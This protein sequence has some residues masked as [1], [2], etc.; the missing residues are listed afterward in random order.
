MDLKS[1]S[2]WY[3]YSRARDEMFAATDM[4]FAPWYVVRSDDKKRAR[5]NLI[6]HLLGQI[7]YEELPREKIKLPKREKPRGYQRAG[8]AC[9]L[10]RGGVSDA[11]GLPDSTRACLFDLD[12]VLTQTAKLHAAAWKEMFDDYLRERA[13][14]T[15]E[16]FVP[17]EQ[18][19]TTR[20][21]STASCASTAR[22]A[23]LASRGIVLPDDEV[24]RRWP[25]RKDELARRAAATASA[26]RPTRARCA[27][28]RR[29]ATRGLQD[30]GG[31]VEQALPGGARVGRASPTCSTC[32]STATSPSEEHLAGKPAP[33][34]FLA[35]AARRRRRRRRRRPCSRTRSPAS[36]PGAPGHFGYVVGVDRAGQA[37]ELARHGADVVVDDLAALLEAP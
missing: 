30:G 4:P 23:F 2:R 11:A 31:V 15:G 36:R 27:T 28:S 10:H 25:R 6:T 16:P 13:A 5:L 1:Y 19:A 26:S 18:Y 29:R 22:T 14:Q 21:T 3:D 37:A 17:F 34:T 8:A 7:P 24:A 33:D 12:G 9:E 20:A 32:A 35:A